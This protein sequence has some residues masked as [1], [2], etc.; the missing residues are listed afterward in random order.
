[1]TVTLAEVDGSSLHV[2]GDFV[3]KLALIKDRATMELDPSQVETATGEFDVIL[4]LR[5]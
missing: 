2:Q 3:A 4:P 1:M 5:E